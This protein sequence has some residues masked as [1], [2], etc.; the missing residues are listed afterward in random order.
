MVLSRNFIKNYFIDRIIG[1]EFINSLFIYI[2]VI[3]LI[4]SIGLV[5]FGA[6]LSPVRAPGSGPGGRRF[7]SS[8]PD[9]MSF[10]TY[11]I[12]SK[13]R[14]RYYIGSTKDIENRIMEHNS[15]ENPSTKN[16]RP[17]KLITVFEF[18]TH[19]EALILE[20]KIKKRGAK[21]YLKDVIQSG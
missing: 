6:W 4:H 8:R 10:Y 21:R 13:L 5:M 14:N 2:F 20:N 11:I 17:W 7:E 3:T 1:K 12:F 16:G 19:R 18:Q 9:K 15:G